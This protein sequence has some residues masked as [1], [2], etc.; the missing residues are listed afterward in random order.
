MAKTPKRII[1]VGEEPKD[2]PKT[3]GYWASYKGHDYNLNTETAH[4]FWYRERTKQE[5]KGMR[6]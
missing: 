3:T 6:P 1:V 4:Q 2:F 5:A